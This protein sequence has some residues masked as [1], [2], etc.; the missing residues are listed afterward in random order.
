MEL[1]ILS[2]GYKIIKHTIQYMFVNMDELD[3]YT[4]F[5]ELRDDAQT[6][7]KNIHDKV[8]Q[9]TFINHI[10][11]V[12]EYTVALNDQVFSKQVLDF[13]IDMFMFIG[14]L[15]YDSVE[16]VL[17]TLTASRIVARDLIE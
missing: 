8:A 17:D 12:M 1:L 3:I 16:N 5:L 13:L 6:I 4:K 11:D 9:N 7:A 14:E 15:D 2:I 10:A